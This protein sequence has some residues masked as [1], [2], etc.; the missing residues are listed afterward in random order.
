VTGFI[1]VCAAMVVLAVVWVAWPLMRTADGGGSRTE[2]RVLIGVLALALPLLAGGLYAKLS[3]W[4]WND[5]MTAH[6]VQ[7]SRQL[8]EM[9]ARVRENPKD[10][11]GWARLG[12]AYMSLA[13]YD[14]AVRA[15]EQA[16]RL[17]G[18]EDP[19]LTTALAEALV[20]SDESS[21]Q[22]RAGALFEEALR[23]APSH[24]KALFYSSIGAMRSGKLELARDRFKLLLAQNPPEQIRPMLERQ[25]QDLEEQ[26]AQGGQ[27]PT[28]PVLASRPA[29]GA[30]RS[31]KVAVAVAPQIQ[32][33]LREPLTLFILARDPA[34]GG[35]PLAVERRAASELPLTVELSEAD[36]MLSTRTIADVN[37]VQIVARL[38][39]SGAPQQQSGDFFGEARLQ[40]DASNSDQEYSVNIV[41][42]QR[43]P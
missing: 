40:F 26:I 35:P 21:L 30:K 20:L 22:D 17:T 18:A 5:P 11:D 16:Y 6:A 4:K 27:S 31:V 19:N 12:R 13:Q 14:A 43:V 2:R 42:D 8:G 7:L 28:E 39:R 36:A 24:P 32:Q 34:A 1:I 9:Q 3:T 29:P 23:R 41:I 38:S 25:I 37:A 33:Q 10:V 15:Y